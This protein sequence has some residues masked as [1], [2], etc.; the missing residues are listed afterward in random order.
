M[1]AA[2]RMEYFITGLVHYLEP[3]KPGCA[4]HA[5]QEMNRGVT[6]PSVHEMQKAPPAM[7]SGALIT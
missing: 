7:A 3:E 5:K 1:I 4:M 6:L 2:G